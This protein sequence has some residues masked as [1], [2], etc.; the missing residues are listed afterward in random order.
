MAVNVI[1]V[2]SRQDV[3]GKTFFALILMGG[4]EFVQSRKTGSWYATSCKSSITTT[5]PE[6]FCKGLIGKTIPGEIQRMEVDPYE[7]T[8]EETGE[9]VTLTHKYRYNPKP[10]SVSIEETV[11]APEMAAVHS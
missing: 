10:N 6:Q 2:V 3:A 8:V 5:F 4:M 7:Y 9:V 11:F 1:D